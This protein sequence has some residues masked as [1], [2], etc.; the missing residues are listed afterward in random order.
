[1]GSEFAARLSGRVLRSTVL[2]TVVVLLE[3]ILMA[4]LSF[5]TP[6][7]VAAVFRMVAVSLALLFVGISL[8]AVRG[9]RI[10]RGVL[11][12]ERPFWSTTHSIAGLHSAVRDPT[13][14][15]WTVLGFGNNGF[16]ALNGWRKVAPYGWCR[17]LA[18][19]PPNAVVLR[20]AQAT[21]I[22]TPDRPDEFLQQAQLLAGP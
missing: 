20:T 2:G 16:F 4:V 21:Y 15:R 9:Y 7:P 10:E 11:R 3:C 14:L 8:V 18:T 5:F 17:V 1:M 6:H 13:A 22:V 19:D 12:V